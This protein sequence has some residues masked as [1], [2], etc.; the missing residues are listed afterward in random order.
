LI[1]LF[2]QFL[3]LLLVLVRFPLRILEVVTIRELL[4]SEG[5]EGFLFEH[6]EVS[7]KGFS[8][9]WR[10]SVKRVRIAGQHLPGVLDGAQIVDPCFNIPIREKVKIIGTEDCSAV[11]GHRVLPGNNRAAEAIHRLLQTLSQK[12]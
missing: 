10:G 2:S 9:V 12:D 5:I 1:I 8:L 11:R 4:E 3:L 7:L 6:P